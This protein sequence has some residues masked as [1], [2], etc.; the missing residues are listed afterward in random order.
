MKDDIDSFVFLYKKELHIAEH[1]TVFK[2]DLNNRFVYKEL[3]NGD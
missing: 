2:S 3:F 1:L